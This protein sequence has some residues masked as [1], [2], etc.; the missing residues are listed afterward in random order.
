MVAQSRTARRPPA[1]AVLCTVF[2]AL[3]ML[4]SGGV[5][6]ATEVVLS[7]VSGA[8]QEGDL[9]GEGETE[10][11]GEDIVGPLNILL[12]G[13][14]TRPSR[15]DETPRADAIMIVHINRNLDRGYLISLPRDLIVDIPPEPTTGYPGG[16]DRLNAAMFHGANPVAGEEGPNVERGFALLARTIAELTGIERF[17]AGVVLRFEGFREIVDAMGGVT[18]ELTERIVSEHRQ[19]DGTH[20]PVGCGSYCGPQMVYEPGA[21]PCGE[22]NEARD[23]AFRCELSGWQALDVV[24]QRKS[25]DEG[26]Y[27]RQENQQRVLRAMMDQAFSR[28]MVTNPVALRELLQAIGDSMI[29][30]GRGHEVVD[31]AF[32]LRSL[33]SSS[34]VM[35]GLP[36]AGV[37]TGSAYQG[38]QLRPEA[39][40]LF[41][42]MQRDQ[43]DQFLL[44]HTDFVG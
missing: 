33:R 32:A 10:T 37:G 16:Q 30:D 2:G 18:V 39:F 15:P 35:V 43:L 9:F 25:L 31:F 4:G 36:A 17:D 8:I 13:L 44:E 11:Y 14:D 38:E 40:G 21:P 41:E 28:D 27:G 7:Q 42:A 29:F 20:R 19:P 1:W 23:G 26:D 3:L 5:L 24:R 34:V 12:A 22:A 6:V